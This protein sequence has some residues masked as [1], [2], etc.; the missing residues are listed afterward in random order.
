MIRI[1]LL[2]SWTDD[3]KNYWKKMTKKNLTWDQFLLVDNNPDYYVVV[4]ATNKKIDK[5][6]AILLS[7]EP[8]LEHKLDSNG[9]YA[10][11]FH[12]HTM[13]N[14]EWH[15]SLSHFDL[16]YYSPKKTNNLSAILSDK[17]FD[18]GHI[19]RIDL[20]KKLGKYVD[21]YGTDVGYKNFKKQL[22]YHEKD[23]GLFPYKYTIAVENQFIPN[24]ITE[25]LFDGIL[26]ECLTFYRGAPNVDD[27]IDKRCFIKL[28]D[29]ID[30]SIQIIKK[31]IENKEWEKRIQIIRSEKRR[32]MN[33]Y[34]LFARLSNIIESK[35]NF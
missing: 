27:W 12:S 11:M 10:T 9:Y 19:F 18:P 13:N 25:K 15:L 1:Q 21:M 28:S 32:I 8:Y 3:L 5:S 29:N 20:C 16:L 26:S 35:N 24:Y 22:P 7:M 6:R 14:M 2:C 4:N 34:N 30:N 23:E 17:Y 31:S 33:E